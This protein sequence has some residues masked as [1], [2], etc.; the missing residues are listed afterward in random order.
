MRRGEPLTSLRFEVSDE[1]IF[2]CRSD[3]VGNHLQRDKAAPG[4]DK[5]LLLRRQRPAQLFRGG[6]NDRSMK[7]PN[8]RWVCKQIFP[9]THSAFGIRNG[10]A[11]RLCSLD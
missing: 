11:S 4:R 5:L 9:K 6:L 1:L 3:R 10:Q 2:V 7:P 8:W